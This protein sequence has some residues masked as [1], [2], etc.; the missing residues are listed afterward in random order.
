M[1]HK[2]RTL[3]ISA[4]DMKVLSA[5]LSDGKVHIT[6]VE[7]GEQQNKSQFTCI[8]TSGPRRSQILL[9]TGKALL[10]EWAANGPYF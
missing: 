8:E 5:V 3:T 6:Y 1:D 7:T 2:V 4:P 9:H 10:Q